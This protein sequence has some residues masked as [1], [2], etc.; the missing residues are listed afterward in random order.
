MTIRP[1]FSRQLLSVALALASLG[2]GMSA[3][4]ALAAPPAQLKTQVPGFYRYAVG[5]F[6]VTALYDGYVDLDSKLLKGMRAQQIQSLMARM[7]MQDSKGV[8]TAVNA[9]LVHTGERLILVD[10]GSASCFGPTLGRVLENVRAAGY[11]PEAVDTVLLT[12]MHPDH[13]CGLL[14]ADGKPAFTR[15]TVW[16]AQ[17]DADF[18][19]SEKIAAAA[20]EG[21]QPFFRMAREAVAPYQAAG[22]FRTFKAGEAIVAGVSVLPTHGHTPGHSSYLLTSGTQKLLVW[23]DIVH[24]HAVQ[25]MHPEVSLE[26]DTDQKKA[27]ATRKALF[28]QAAKA[29]WGIA[30]A[31]LPFPGLG[32]IRKDAQ[33]YA[34][35]PV[36][37]GP[38]RSDR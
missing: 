22:T 13:M 2:A 19:L 3:A 11:A 9:Y 29:G 21:N 31:H 32:R 26:F 14:G 28:A 24:N 36:E 8:Q 15:A 10:A 18:W 5:D 37:F 6:E 30:G 35:V 16:A 17:E 23:G 7:F 4:P 25:F 20:P 34:W 27:I 38:I 12:H 33:G 1:A